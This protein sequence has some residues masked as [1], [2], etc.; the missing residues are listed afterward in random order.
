MSH[1]NIK[2]VRDRAWHYL[3]CET[4]AHAGMTLAEMQQF[5]A[6]TY[7]PSPEQLD[8]LARRMGLQQ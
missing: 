4:A 3:S 6:G 8:K 7:A 1:I 5:I 2:A